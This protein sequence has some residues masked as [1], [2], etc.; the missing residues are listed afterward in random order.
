MELMDK[1]SFCDVMVYVGVVV[2]IIII[3]GL[4]GWVGF[5]VSV[6]CSVID[7]LLILLV[8]LNCLV[9]VWLVFSEYYMLCVN[10]LVV[11]QEILLMLFGGKM[12]MDECFVVVDWQIGVIGCL[13][14]EVVL[15][16]FDCCIDQ[17]VSVGM[18]DILFCY[19]VVI[20]CYLEFWGLMWFDCG[21]Y[22]FM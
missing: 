13:W 9:L 7:M 5:I 2:N 4:V 16:S 14:L 22:M 17:C 3:D 1:V 21:Y 12:V 6:V 19:V 18:Y 8:C 11:G 10:I 15:V 20:I